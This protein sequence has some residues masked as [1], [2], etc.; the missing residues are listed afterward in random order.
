MAVDDRSH[1][2]AG[3]G[4]LPSGGRVIAPVFRTDQ[5]SFSGDRM[6]WSACGE[7]YRLRTHV[8]RCWIIL[9]GELFYGSWLR[10]CGNTKPDAGI[11][12][13][14]TPGALGAASRQ[15]A[16][17]IVLGATDLGRKASPTPSYQRQSAKDQQPRVRNQISSA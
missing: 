15:I 5:C 3:P 13:I 14:P 11:L 7:V 10:Y 16:L 6:Q 4:Q 1:G 12:S 17:R 9:D 2:N 8:A